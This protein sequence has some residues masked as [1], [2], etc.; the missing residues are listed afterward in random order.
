MELIQQIK[1]KEVELDNLKEQYNQGIE[2]ERIAVL[3]SKSQGMVKSLY[4]LGFTF[5]SSCGD[6]EQYLKFHRVFKRDFTA[7]LKPYIKEIKIGKPNHFDISGFIKMNND[8]IY[9]FRIED[10]RWSKDSMLIRTAKDFNDYSGGS[11]SYIKLNKD[12]EGTLL[13]YLG[14]R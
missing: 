2:R 13:S 9:W 1:Q 6:T 11:N 12:F 5:E 3:N 4:L 10:L 8:N 7:L 14:V